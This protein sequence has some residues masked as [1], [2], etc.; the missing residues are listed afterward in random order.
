MSA[1][2]P[3]GPERKRR[4]RERARQLREA[5]RERPASVPGRSGESVDILAEI[6]EAIRAQSVLLGRLVH[7]VEKRTAE[8]TGTARD[9]LERPG[10]ERDGAEGARVP[11]GADA[12]VRARLSS[13]TGSREPYV[14]NQETG[15]RDAG[16]TEPDEELA[17]RI[18]G[19]LGRAHEPTGAP[20]M[21][22]ALDVPLRAVVAELERLQGAGRVERL[23]PEIPS[24][25][26][27][28]ARWR[29]PGRVESPA[30]TIRCDA[31]REHQLSGHRRDPVSGRFRCYQCEPELDPVAARYP[32]EYAQIHGG[33]KQ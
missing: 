11:A 26:N 32:V 27:S 4:A 1:T 3:T 22:D 24:S 9:A 28:P 19:I 14:P 20:A 33:T 13:P 23:E 6:L 29:L 5:S 15:T 7:S 25:A 17:G 8:R 30:E 16:R 31:Y 10:T 21:S 2:D 12:R 18:L